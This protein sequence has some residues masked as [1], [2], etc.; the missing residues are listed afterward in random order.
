MTVNEV[1][2]PVIV[3]EKSLPCP[4]IHSGAAPLP[5]CVCADRLLLDD[6]RRLHEGV[7]LAMIGEGASFGEGEAERA[8]IG[9][10][11]GIDVG[12]EGGAIIAGDG[13]GRARGIGPG[14]GRSHLNSDGGRAE[15]EGAAGG[16]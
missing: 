10:D 16:N 6:H 3:C 8:A 14:N 7:N 2:T 4:R 13:M 9:R 5:H 1:C 11:G 12:V 15:C